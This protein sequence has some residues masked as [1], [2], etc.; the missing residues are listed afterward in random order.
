MRF[1]QGYKEQQ[2]KLHA[3]GDYGVSGF[4]HAD[5]VMQL[6]KQL[7]TRS[8]LDYGSGQQTLQKGI[9][10][11]IT[12]YDPFVVGCEEEPTTHDLVVCS[13]VLEHIE[14]DCVADVL[15]HIWSKTTKLL[16]V[17]VACR[18]AKKYLEDGR[19]A[20][21]IQ[22]SPSW[23]LLK[24]IPYFEPVYFQTYVGGFVAVLTPKVGF[25]V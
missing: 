22:E 21:L 7:N 13:D 19:N 12:N 6:A 24:L 20:H 8:I 23:W 14:P 3:A 25:L 15:Q 1:S 5:Q 10:F 9:P 16:F 4:K 17:D 11:P 2:K 18:P